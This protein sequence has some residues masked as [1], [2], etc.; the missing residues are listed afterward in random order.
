MRHAIFRFPIGGVAAGCSCARFDGSSSTTLY[1]PLPLSSTKVC[2]RAD[3]H[4]LHRTFRSLLLIAL[5]VSF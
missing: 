4:D 5:P 3:V 2:M 1:N